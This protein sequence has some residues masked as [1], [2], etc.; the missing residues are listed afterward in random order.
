MS[1]RV[2]NEE[3]PILEALICIRNR[4]HALKKDRANY[5]RASAVIEIYEE[6][7]EQVRKLNEIREL[8]I[9][10]PKSN[11]R[12]NDVLDDVFQ[13]LSLFFMAIG[14]NRESPATYVQ[15]ATIKQCLD[16]LNESGVYTLDELIP[17]ESRL[18]EMKKIITNE[19][20][21]VISKLLKQKLLSCE[22]TLK[23]LR[24]SES[25]ISDELLPVHQRLVEIKRLLGDLGLS[26]SQSNDIR[27][28]QDELREIDSKR[29]DGKFMASDDSI[30]TG[31]AQVI[32]LLEECYEHVHELIVTQ[33]CVA[34][35]LKHIYDRLIEL[36]SQLENLVLTHRWTLRETDLWMYQ[37]QLTEIDNM[38][39]DGK[40]YDKDGNLL[41]SSEPIAEP[42]MPIHN[43]LQTVRKFLKE[44]K[45]FGTPFTARE[46]YPYQMKL[47]SIDN[48]RVDG[49]FID[50]DGS[51]PEGQGIIAALLNECYDI[52]Y[53]LKADVEEDGYE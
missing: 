20:N 44:I 12:V 2:P 16:N 47:A 7:T 11:N 46:L 23:M 5:I 25:N 43:Q 8:T 26:G 40:F 17:Y 10:E 34:G 18:E 36:K 39:K 30:P 53:E 1:S 37:I 48:L 51:I 35:T 14:K 4:L 42:L 9:Q 45:K 22:E 27:L 3:L 49:K 24:E 13:L 6:V 21:N 32:S 38:R 31:Q 19:E 15:L 29:I 41:S 52:L 33:D 28:I 50:D